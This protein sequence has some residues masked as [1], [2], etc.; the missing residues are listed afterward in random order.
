MT[1]FKEWS[2]LDTNEAKSEIFYGGYSDAQVSELSSLSGFRRGEFPTRYLGLP[3]SPKKISAATLQPFIDRITAKLHSWTVKFL[4]FAGKVTMIYSVI[5]G[6][7]NFWSSVFVLPKW[8]YAKIDSLCSGFL[9]KNSTTSA[10]GARV[11]WENICRPKQ[12]GGLGIRRLE[13][14]E[15]VF[16]LKRVWLF[17]YGSGSLWVPWLANN[18]FGGRSFWIINDSP[19]FS[20]TVRSMLQL[21]QELQLFLR[22]P[23][24]LIF[25]SSGPRA[26][27]IPLNATVSQAVSNG[28]WN[29]P[30]ARSALAVTLHIILLTTPVP[31]AAAGSDVYLW[32]NQTGG[33]GP[34]FSSRNTWERIRNHSPLVTWH[35]V[36]WYMTT[37]PASLSDMVEKCEQIQGPHAR[38]AVVVLKFLNQVI[39]YSLWRERN[40]RIF[41]GVS[42]QQEVFFRGVDRALRDR[43]LSLSRPST[44]QP[45]PS[46]LELYFW[47]LSPFS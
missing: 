8:F 29:L 4:S 18:R 34:S 16:R 40:A 22:C 2:G 44:T 9:W 31:N 3:L 25:G 11:S 37:T 41:R 47:F 32:R 33:F 30:P 6:M 36:V 27:R 28:N 23:L 42:T 17:F 24:H 45:L 19:R 1:N 26:L 20:T 10:A 21:K 5:Y 15:K 46:L 7:V 43:L 35:P 12:E 13:E 14:F 38:R 39:I